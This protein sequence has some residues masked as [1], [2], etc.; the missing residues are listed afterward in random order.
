MLIILLIL[1]L[2]SIAACGGNGS[3][4]AP[5]DDI[6][7]TAYQERPG[8]VFE[9]QSSMEFIYS[10]GKTASVTQK[11][12]QSFSQVDSIPEKYGYSGDLG[13]PYILSTTTVDGELDGYEYISADGTEI[14]DDDLD[15]FT[16]VD[17]QTISGSDEPEDVSLGDTFTF[18][19]ESTLFDSDTAE[20][21]G[22]RIIEG[23]FTVAEEETVTVPAGTFHCLRIDLG[24]EI[25]ITERGITDTMTTVGSGWF[26]VENGFGPKL[27]GTMDIT[28]NEF[29]LT[30]TAT[31]ERVL[32]DYE[33]GSVVQLQNLTPIRFVTL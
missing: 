10:D 27:T 4:E 12:T 26:D 14:V 7:I 33:I 18:R 19:E 17:A 15:T 8:D 13:G 11:E 1:I 23:T 24:L 25:S 3:D 5:T 31:L 6:F 9:Y 2:A 30:C 32:V 28:M 16:R 20:E 22:A 29:G 21:V